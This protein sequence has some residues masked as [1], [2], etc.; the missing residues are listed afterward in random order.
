MAKKS[1]IAQNEKRKATVERHAARRAELKEIIRRPS[2]S[3]AERRAAVEELRRQP[4]N[5][6]ATR[7]ARRPEAQCLRREGP[8]PPGAEDG[9]GDA[10]RLRLGSMV[11]VEFPHSPGARCARSR[12][13][14][15]VPRTHRPG[16]G[17]A[18]PVRMGGLSSKRVARRR[19]AD[20]VPTRSSC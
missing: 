12:S 15:A 18:R 3:D 5:A 13:K 2:S 1:K 20:T 19:P 4:R 7:L 6:S 8:Q 9:R 16:H 14:R 17:P 11:A 10:V